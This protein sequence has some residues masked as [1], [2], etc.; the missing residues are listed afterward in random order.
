MSGGKNGDIYRVVATP[1]KLENINRLRRCLQYRIDSGRALP[2]GARLIIKG[3]VLKQG[4]D[5]AREASVHQFLS[6]Q[7]NPIVLQQPRGCGQNASVTPAQH[8]P[9][10]YFAGLV[11]ADLIKQ[12][13]DPTRVK[14]AQLYV[15]VMQDLGAAL[16]LWNHIR[17]RRT[18]TPD[19]Y[20][21]VEK[22]AAGL[23]L[24]GVYHADL[25]NYNIF[26]S[27]ID[28][29]PHAYILDFGFA[30]WRDGHAAK[31]KAALEAMFNGRVMADMFNLHP[32]G[33]NVQRHANQVLLGRGYRRYQ[34]NK[35]LMQRYSQDHG[36]SDDDLWQARVRAW[37]CVTRGVQRPSEQAERF[38]RFREQKAANKQSSP[39]EGEIRSATQQ[40]VDRA[41]AILKPNTTVAAQKPPA[42]SSVINL[43][44]NND[45][46]GPS[47]RPRTQK[48]AS[49][50]RS[51]SVINLMSNNSPTRRSNSG[52]T[53][54]TRRSSRGTTASSRSRASSGNTASSRRR[55]S[56]GNTVSG[57]RRS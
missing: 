6:G 13:G 34:A 16:P 26:M 21:A 27:T 39:E 57:R 4:S 11:P 8:V 20:A 9:T 17:S 33:T 25:H 23:W 18:L 43:I 55:A 24:S 38:R 42:N 47:K 19:E 46:A 10:F 44:S 31:A 41:A 15:T 51:P 49:P 36:F 54:G 5:P 52:A 40:V 32:N 30:V 35:T 45:A 29:R 3:E 22:A 28:D 48:Q 12:C 53:G 2:P 37:G 50:K 56:S 1:S 7:T 14:K